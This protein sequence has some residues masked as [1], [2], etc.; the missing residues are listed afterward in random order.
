MIRFGNLNITKMPKKATKKKGGK[1]QVVKLSSQELSEDELSENEVSEN[2]VS[3]QEIDLIEEDSNSDVTEVLDVSK[4]PNFESDISELTTFNKKLDETSRLNVYLDKFIPWFNDRQNQRL[5]EAKE[6]E[7][8]RLMFIRG[9]NKTATLLRNIKKKND[10][11]SA[12]KANS[13]REYGFNKEIDVPK[14]FLDFFS[15]HL[16]KEVSIKKKSGDTNLILVQKKMKRPDIT[17]LLYE[18]C[19]QKNLKLASDKRVIKPD[20][21]L[22]KLFAGALEDGENLTFTNF[23]TK[24]KYVMDKNK[25]T[26]KKKNKNV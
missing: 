12:K 10:K 16:P 6:D 9:L 15:K 17:A 14:I 1:K 4:S 3:S 11:R 24:L 21:N 20:K 8:K 19:T 23:Q 22:R 26:S 25:I 13:T 18:Y 7:R 5:K 2:E